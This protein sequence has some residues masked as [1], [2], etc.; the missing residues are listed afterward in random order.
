M[1]TMQVKKETIERLKKHLEK[2]GDTM[3]IVINRLLDAVE[4]QNGKN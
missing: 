1:A 3:D 4:N 2:Y